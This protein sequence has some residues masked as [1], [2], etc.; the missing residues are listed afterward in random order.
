MWP[1][2]VI[3]VAW[4]NSWNASRCSEFLVFPRALYSS[5]QGPVY[6]GSYNLQLTHRS[7]FVSKT[8]YFWSQLQQFCF[9]LFCF[10]SLC[11]ASLHIFCFSLYMYCVKLFVGRLYTELVIIPTCFPTFCFSAIAIRL[12]TFLPAHYCKGLNQ[13]FI[14]GMCVCMYIQYVRMWLSYLENHQCTISDTCFVYLTCMHRHTGAWR[15]ARH[16]THAY[17]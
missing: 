8:T 16:H 3:L 17:S 6:L 5:P 12:V 11:T 15:N 2:F 4:M 1:D 10:F 9:V 13:G 14:L 7:I